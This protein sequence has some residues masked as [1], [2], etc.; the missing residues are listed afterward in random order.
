MSAAVAADS[1]L[2]VRMSQSV[3]YLFLFS[4]TYRLFITVTRLG[5][6]ETAIDICVVAAA[7]SLPIGVTAPSTM[8]VMC[9]VRSVLDWV[10][11]R[12]SGRC[13]AKRPFYIGLL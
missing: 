2:P 8:T 3:P 9:V 12:P 4:L 10:G 11:D 6:R 1:N 5:C 7:S 13:C